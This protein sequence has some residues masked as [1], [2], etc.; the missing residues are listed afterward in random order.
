MCRA[1]SEGWGDFTA[2]LLLAR[3]GDDLRGAYPFSVYTTQGYAGDPGYFGIRR[4]P[5][6]VNFDINGLMFRHMSN[7]MQLPA[8]P[9]QAQNQNSEV[10]N[11]GEI[12]AAA[13][14]E[15]YVALHEAAPGVPFL[16]VRSKMARYIV[17]GLSLVP[18]EA[19]PLEMRDA[20]LAAA[21]AESPADYAVM[22]QAFARRGFGSCAVAPPA[23]S[24]TFIGIVD[25]TIIA[26]NPQMASLDIADGCD[27]DSIIDTGETATV[28]VRLVNQ[29]HAPLTDLDVAVTSDV[30]GVT[31]HTPPTRLDRLESFQAHDLEIA[32]SLEAGIGEALAGDL[33][34]QVTSSGGCEETVKLPISFRL[35]VDDVRSHSA[36]DTFDALLSFWEPWAIAWRH[37]R[38][39]PLDGIWHADDLAFVSD[40]RLTSPRLV[41]DADKPLTISFSHRYSF[42]MTNGTSWDGGV[43]EYSIDGGE[44]WA[45][46]AELTDPGYTAI[47]TTESGNPLGDRPAYTGRSAAYPA[48]ETV[49]LALGTGIAGQTF[50]FRFRLGTDAG[51]GGPGWD[52][53]D[54]AFDGIVGTPFPAQ[55]ADDGICTPIKDDPILS[56][57][58][59]CCQTGGGSD[60][61]LLTLGVLGLF[62]RRR[63][64]T[65]RARSRSRA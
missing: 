39:S 44:T 36:T 13:L 28:K 54:V 12:W 43:L 42:E 56:G 23:G 21:L 35:N 34:L 10:H 17:N 49:T 6:S 65:A 16:D 64:V 3:P 24:V 62:A 63:R 25:S 57:G 26:G 20:L 11:A 58:G 41:A 47:L 59:G 7:G 60:T 29:G 27:D 55:V 2:L 9:L 18:E 46:I 61:A 40:T 30:P 38:E 52:I 32:V 15:V 1:M 51:T 22:S 37:E 4:A 45:D 19:S 53:D 8:H 31:V 50:R 5:Y 14:W 33:A 48:Y